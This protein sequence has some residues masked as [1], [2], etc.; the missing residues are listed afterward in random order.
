MAL[1][2]AHGNL[3]N[4]SGI[5]TL[6][7][8]ISETGSKTP[9]RE[10]QQDTALRSAED[11][12]PLHYKGLCPLRSEWLSRRPSHLDQLEADGDDGGEEPVG[13]PDEAHGPGP[14]ALTEQL[15]PDHR[16][17]RA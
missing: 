15:G 16:R 9:C 11:A 13:E 4:L 6:H 8:I 14:W 10:V 2:P 7:C 5:F 1:R 12:C 3:L 17:D